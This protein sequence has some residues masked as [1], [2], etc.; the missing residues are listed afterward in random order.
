M[1]IT[2][3]VVPVHRGVKSFV[4]VDSFVHL[5]HCDTDDAGRRVGTGHKYVR[6]FFVE[7]FHCGVQPV[8][9]S[10]KVKSESRFFRFLR[11]QSDYR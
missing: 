9:E 7:T 10:G 6:T 3:L 2:G 5:S 11:Y 1:E 8:V 4:F